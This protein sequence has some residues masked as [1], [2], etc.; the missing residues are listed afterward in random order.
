MPEV[1]LGDTHVAIGDTHL[2]AEFPREERAPIIRTVTARRLADGQLVGE[3]VE[4][5]AAADG[6]GNGS[7]N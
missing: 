3:I 2:T 6:P 5:P 1:K 7:G 4:R